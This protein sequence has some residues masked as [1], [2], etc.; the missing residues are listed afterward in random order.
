[1]L[2]SFLHQKIFN[3]NQL[4]YFFSSC[5]Y[6]YFGSPTTPGGK[7]EPCVCNGVPCDRTTG[8]CLNCRGNT[9]G[10]H[11]ER[12]KPQHYGDPIIANCQPCACDPLG[13]LGPDCDPLTGQCECK[14][15]FTG[16][17]CDKCQVC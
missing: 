11:C 5:D 10:W 12:C 4:F 8:Q 3:L 9:E 16:R 15:R 13:S 17:T 1:M 7:C 6:G 2:K 14:D